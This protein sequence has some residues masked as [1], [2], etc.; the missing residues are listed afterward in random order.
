MLRPLSWLASLLLLSACSHHPEPPA[1]LDSRIDQLVAGAY[2]PPR[3]A[4]QGWHA[5]WTLDDEVMDVDWL[6]PAQASALPVIL[7]LPGLGEDSRA[8]E[9]WRRAWAQAGYAVL[10]V[11]A[12]R[13][14]RSIYASKEAQAGAFQGIARRAYAADALQR[15]LVQLDLVLREARRRASAGDDAFSRVDWHRQAVAGFD[16]GTQT[17]VALST[18]QHGWAPRVAI[19]LSP[20]APAPELAR[21]VSIPLLGVSGQADED[22]FSNWV[23]PAQRHQM[24]WQ[25]IEAAGSYQLL[26]DRMTHAQLGGTFAAEPGRAAGDRPHARPGTGGAPG[27]GPGMGGGQ[28]EPGGSARS[29][30]RRNEGG[31]RERYGRGGEGEVDPRRAAILLATSVA[32]LDTCLRNDAEARHWLEWEANR[33]MTP[34]ARLEAKTRTP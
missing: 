4:V 30:E 3:L 20:Y 34:G 22:P 28:G 1:S 10:S 17:A 5:E 19:L 9:P 26:L 24:F 8:G 25:H 7:Y 2:Q 27:G 14:G 21:Q 18:G 31:G 16:L 15:R 11:Q 6:A 29:A 13:D 23:T 33:W 32:F 12:H